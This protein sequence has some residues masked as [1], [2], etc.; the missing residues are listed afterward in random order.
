MELSEVQTRLV[1]RLEAQDIAVPSELL[2][3]AN[4]PQCAAGR[5]QA[6]FA[7]RQIENAG[8]TSRLFLAR[9]IA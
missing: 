7:Y 5:C 4:R 1:A 9:R 3:V 6:S 8:P 2:A